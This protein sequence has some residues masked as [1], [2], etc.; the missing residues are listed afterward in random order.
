MPPQI[1]KGCMN[2][3][4]LLRG[5]LGKN[6]QILGPFFCLIYDSKLDKRKTRIPIGTREKGLHLCDG[7]EKKA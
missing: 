6:M 7:Q 1:E 4:A 5:H 3:F 2:Y